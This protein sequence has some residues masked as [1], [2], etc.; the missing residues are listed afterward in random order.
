MKSFWDD[1]ADNGNSVKS[2]TDQNGDM[3]CSYYNEPKVER[4]EW[5]KDYKGK[6][7]KGA[8][9]FGEAD[10]HTSYSHHQPY[11]PKE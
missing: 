2:I 5:K 1:Q 10:P 7:G 3:E 9:A 4:F 8:L 11:P 6:D